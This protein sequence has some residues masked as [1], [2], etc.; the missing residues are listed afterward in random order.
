[1]K[2]SQ[3]R[4][5]KRDLKSKK[6]LDIKTLKMKSDKKQARIESKKKTPQ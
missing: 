3:Q 5:T 4:V 6:Q 1:M 2:R